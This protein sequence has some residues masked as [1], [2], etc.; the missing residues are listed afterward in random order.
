MCV[1]TY[2]YAPIYP[3][4]TTIK[5]PFANVFF[6]LCC[7][8][9]RDLDDAPRQRTRGQDCLRRPTRSVAVTGQPPRDGAGLGATGAT[10]SPGFTSLASR[11]QTWLGSPRSTSFQNGKIIEP[12][13]GRC[14]HCRVWF[15]K[16][17][18][19]DCLI[20]IFCTNDMCKVKSP[21]H[22]HIFRGFHGDF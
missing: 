1:C 13:N 5:P 14:S 17:K 20:N 16:F 11:N 9:H 3:H 22:H 4:E 10:L 12:L 2:Q 8:T 18:S 15:G 7:W 19:I 6:G 21:L